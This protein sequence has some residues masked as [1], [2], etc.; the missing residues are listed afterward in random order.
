MYNLR[1]LISDSSPQAPKQMSTPRLG[2][3]LG[4]DFSSGAAI[5]RNTWNSKIRNS[6][7]KNIA[8]PRAFTMISGKRSL[9]LSKWGGDPL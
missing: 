1:I 8:D 6:R 7:R 2:S 5:G 4:E 9:F 3:S